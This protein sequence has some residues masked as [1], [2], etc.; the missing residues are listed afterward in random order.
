MKKAALK[1]S[2]GANCCRQQKLIS[3]SAFYWMRC[4]N[5]YE[6]TLLTNTI[7]V[8]HLVYFCNFFHYWKSSGLKYCFIP[9]YSLV[10]KQ[11]LHRWPVNTALLSAFWI[12]SL[13]DKW[14]TPAIL[15]AHQL[16][17]SL[18]SQGKSMTEL[19]GPSHWQTAKIPGVK[20]YTCSASFSPS[21]GEQWSN[22]GV[23]DRESRLQWQFLHWQ[24]KL[25]LNLYWWDPLILYIYLI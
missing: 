10:V 24:C 25:H 15:I 13:G 19:Q 18:K 21:S 6:S 23:G 12:C 14:Q 7:L 20:S 2:R 9:K 4:W 11:I 17:D 1:F 5:N 8:A 22:G 3:V 16:W